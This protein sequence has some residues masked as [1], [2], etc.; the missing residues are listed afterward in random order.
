MKQERKKKIVS[1]P[2]GWVNYHYFSGRVAKSLVHLNDKFAE[3]FHQKKTQET[4]L[5]VLPLH[6]PTP[7]G[8]RVGILTTLYIMIKTH[9]YFPTIDK[10]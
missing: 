2:F 3:N 9:T 4:S 10:H 8:K 7:N 6:S 1:S 5:S